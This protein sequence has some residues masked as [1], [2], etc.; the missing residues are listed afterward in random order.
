MRVVVTGHEGQVARSL[1]RLG[2]LSGHEV[3]TIGR[4]E[5][6]L[7]AP[8][9]TIVAALSSAR[10]DFIVSAAAYTAV[11]QAEEEPR[12]AE[13]VNVAGA[14]AV[15]QAANRIG[16]PLL[17]LS[18][19][20]VFDGRK[21]GPYRED[22]A[23]NPTG[24]YGCTKLDGERAVM[25]AHGDVAVL[26]TAWVYSPFGRNFVKT[27]LQLAADRSQLRVVADQVG[28]PTGALDI[29]AAVLEAGD[30]LVRSTDP[31][32]RGVFHLA[33]PDEASWADL[34]EHVFTVSGLLGGPSASVVRIA[35]GDFP[36]RARRPAN[37][38]LDCSRI[39]ERH[40]IRL[41]PWRASVA[42]VVA[43]LIQSPNA[44]APK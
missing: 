22:D 40:G 26:R 2:Q 4:P 32:L 13:A 20:Y 41:S 17:H 36:T 38:R 44:K 29:A 37:S 19:D 35:T 11:D 12:F 33:A 34:A 31:G 9:Q 39:A 18:T 6:D 14:A 27:M 3:V 7:S 25:A 10:P 30:N 5:L 8:E 15:A 24:I 21:S 42:N 28:N 1:K 43:E 16:V 23:P